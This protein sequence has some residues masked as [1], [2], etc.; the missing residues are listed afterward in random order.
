MHIERCGQRVD[1]V[2]VTALIVQLPIQYLHLLLMPL[3]QFLL[4]HSLPNLQIVL[5]LLRPMKF[6][7]DR[8]HLTFTTA[9]PARARCKLA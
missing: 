6:V 1:R 4:E 9:G 5:V 8:D 7:V 3:D 2:R